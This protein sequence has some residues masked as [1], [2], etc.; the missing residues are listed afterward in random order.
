MG[1]TFFVDVSD[2][3]CDLAEKGAR[4]VLAKT[5]AIDDFTNSSWLKMKPVTKI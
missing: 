4:F 1:V 5:I 3:G 2:G